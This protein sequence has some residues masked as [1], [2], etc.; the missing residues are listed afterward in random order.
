MRTSIA[1]ALG[2]ILFWAGRA[3]AEE[4]PDLSDLSIEQ[5]AQIKVTSASKQAEPLNEAPASL[6]V[7]DHDQIV[8]SGALTVP[9]I[10]R[11]APNLQVYQQSPSKWVVTARGLNGYP[12]AQ[13]FSNKLLVLID[14]RT[15]YSPLF[16]G[17]YWDMQ[18]VL[19]E[20]IDR[21]EVISG[22]G[23]TLWGANAVN[24]VINIITRSAAT[25]NGFYA[26]ADAGTGEQVVGAR[27]AGSAGKDVSYRTYVRWIH[28]DAF[29]RASGGS[30]HDPWH[31]LGGGFRLDWTPAANDLVT[32][33]GDISG[34]KEDQ[35][36]GAWE[37]VSGRDL[38][39]R[40]NRDMGPERHLQ[41]QAFYDYA[42]R[43]TQPNQGQFF[44]DTYDLDLQDSLP[45]GRRNEVVWGGGARV[46][47]YR[48]E[49][50]PSFFFDPESR[51]LFLANAFVQ[52]TFDLSN[53]VSLTG[54]LKAEHDPYV[55]T[56]LLPDVRIAIKPV[57]STMLW[58]SVSRAVRSATPFDEDVQESAPGVR[59]S[60]NRDFRTEK[61][62]A[63]E[64][65]VRSQPLSSL[66]FSL[67]GFYHRYNDLR[68]VEIAPGPGLDLFWGNQ[69]EG[70]SYGVEGWANFSP[71]PWWTLSAGATLQS[72]NFRFKAGAT[73]PFIGTFQNGIDPGHWI[74]VDSSMNL[75][76]SLTFD[77]HLRAVGR[78]AEADVPA[79]AELGGRLAWNVSNHLQLSVSGSNLLHSEHVE[80]FQGDAIPRKVLVGLQ[81]RP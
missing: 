14:G 21:V 76:R 6:Y 35:G 80:Y 68:T 42:H 79:Y 59:L 34:G 9:E 73:A 15:V 30:A 41:V 75:G 72:E 74:T 5:L 38:V 54:G 44:V 81:W 16:S 37:D 18:D 77:L 12:F 2:S 13:S 31:R 50:I 57:E 28:E 10:L 11:L 67:T 60:G 32:L 19:P 36:V 78:L 62:T 20:D 39:L 53:S 23:A 27:L 58:G 49:G 56:S 29:D 48:I 55:G 22:P 1:L 33:Q 8:R 63:Y 45:L 65:G 3:D 69:L 70:H 7:I 17:V 47:H 46:A 61:L 52:D 24:G 4:Q 64:L 26:Q 25:S 51:N 66:S 43:S 40:W 71:L